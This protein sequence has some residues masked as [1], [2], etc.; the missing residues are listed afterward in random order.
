MMIARGNPVF[1]SRG[2]AAE[3]EWPRLH[4]SQLAKA[5]HSAMIFY[6]LFGSPLYFL[7][8]TYVKENLLL[9]LYESFYNSKIKMMM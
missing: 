4:F 1:F 7:S 3:K 8:F 9:I 6:F 2:A 5:E